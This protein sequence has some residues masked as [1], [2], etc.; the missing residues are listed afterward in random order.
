MALTA[1][2]VPRVRDDIVASLVALLDGDAE[3]VE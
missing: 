1:T 3:L 2:A